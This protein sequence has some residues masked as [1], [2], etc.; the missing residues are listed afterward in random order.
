MS[1]RRDV[2]PGCD[3]SE[4]MEKVGTM[5][6]LR[7]AASLQNLIQKKKNVF[8]I[9]RFILPTADTADMATKFI[10]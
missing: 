3:H 6:I 8:G 9:Q 7:V 5:E 2:G 10:L 1:L 4:S